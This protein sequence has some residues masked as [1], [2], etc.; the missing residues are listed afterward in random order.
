MVQ[1]M[2]TRFLPPA[3]TAPEPDRFADVTEDRRCDGCA[4]RRPVGR[5]D[6]RF[7]RADLRHALRQFRNHGTGERRH[8]GATGNDSNTCRQRRRIQP[9][10]AADE[11]PRIGKV[12]IV[13]AAGNAGF[14]DLIAASLKR[15]GRINQQKR[16]MYL[17]NRAKVGG[18][19]DDER[20]GI[21]QLRRKVF[22]RSTIPAGD[23][24]RPAIRRQPFREPRAETTIS[25]KHDNAVHSI[26]SASP[27]DGTQQASRR[28]KRR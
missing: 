11:I 17:E 13:H 15:S 28:P 21:G 26:R 6:R 18:A 10:D 27:D 8:A 9:A 14:G 25:A 19:V 3:P 5:A 20:A 24:H 16:A 1:P 23:Q 2:P 7:N 22:S 12:D 4:R